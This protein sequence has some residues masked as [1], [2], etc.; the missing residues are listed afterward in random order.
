M[1]NK[2]VKTKEGFGPFPSG[3]LF[4]VK[5]YRHLEAGDPDNPF[6]MFHVKALDE[7]DGTIYHYFDEFAPED[8]AGHD[9]TFNEMFEVIENE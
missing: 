8:T 4:V 5:K 1:I 7:V 6:L 2:T 3:A 9:A